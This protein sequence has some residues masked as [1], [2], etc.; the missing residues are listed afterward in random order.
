MN[1]SSPS[2]TFAF[3]ESLFFLSYFSLS[4]LSGL[5]SELDDSDEDYF[6]FACFFLITFSQD[7][8]ESELDSSDDDYFLIFFT[9]FWGS[10]AFAW[11]FGFGFFL[12]SSSSE[13][14]DDSEDSEDP[15]LSE[16]D[17]FFL[18]CLT[19]FSF[20]GAFFA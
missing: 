17:F 19:A 9:G 15:E 12:A 6:L 8:S 11:T 10:F 3:L 2:I 14:S 20:E 5:P 13:D 7:D 18:A 16:L 4:L 1:I